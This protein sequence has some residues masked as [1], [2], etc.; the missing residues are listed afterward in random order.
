[1]TNPITILSQNFFKELS[2]ASVNWLLGNVGDKIRVET[3]IQI[4]N[5][6]IASTTSDF[7]VN[8]NDGYIGNGWIIDSAQRFVNFNVGDYVYYYDHVAGAPV[9]GGNFYIIAKQ[10]NGS[11]Q[12]NTLANGTG[13]APTAPA[14]TSD[15]QGV[16][17]NQT[18]IN[19]IKY[20][21]GFIGNNASDSFL[22]PI[23]GSEQVFVIKSKAGSDTSTSQMLPLGTL[24]WQDGNAGSLT[25]DFAGSNISICSI[26]GI[27]AAV[28]AGVYTTTYKIIHYTKIPPYVLFAQITNQTKSPIIPP[29]DFAT[30]GKC[31]KWITQIDAM[32]AYTNPNLFVTQVFDTV[33]GNTGWYNSNFSTQKT[34]YSIDG[35]TYN[36]GA[37]A[38]LN[39]A[40]TATIVNFNI[41]NTVDTPFDADTKLVVGI[42]KVPSDPSEYQNNNTLLD[43]NFL[44]N[45][46]NIQVANTVAGDDSGSTNVLINSTTATLNDSGHVNIDLTIQMNASAVASFQKSSTPRYLI[47]VSVEEDEAPTNTSDLVT[48]QV[49]INTFQSVTTDAGMVVIDKTVFIRHP[50]ANPATE[51]IALVAGVKAFTNQSI[52]GGGPHNFEVIDTT[53][54][55]TIG[56]ANYVTSFANTLSLLAKSINTNTN[57]GTLFDSAPAFD[58]SAG[59]TAV[60]DST[61]SSFI[62][63]APGIGT[64]YNGVVL[65]FEITQPGSPFTFNGTLAGGVNEVSIDVFPQDELVGCSNFYIE[66]SGRTAN[67]IKLTSVNAQIIAQNGTKSFELDQFLMLLSSIPLTGSTQQFD[68]QTPRVFNVPSTSIRKFVE[69][70]RRNDLDTGTRWYFSSNYALMWRWETWTAVLGVDPAFFNTA[71]PNNGFNE[72]WF[73]YAQMAGWNLYYNIIVKATKDGVAQTYT[74][75]LRIIPHDYASNSAYTTKTCLTFDPNGLTALL[76]GSGGAAQLVQSGGSNVTINGQVYSRTGTFYNYMNQKTLIVGVFTKT[77]QPASVCVELKVEIYQQGGIAGERIYSSKWVSDGNTWFTSIDGSGKVVLYAYGNSIIALAYFD[78]TTVAFPITAPSFSFSARIYEIGG[79]LETDD[80]VPL[81]TDD[82]VQIPID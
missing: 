33:L 30:A 29:N 1:M 47:F 13:T 41:V 56:C 51:G 77:T 81:T 27:N 9:D 69:V 45:R 70:K 35:L 24:S 19:A 75:T 18:A 11:I 10:D 62:V 22:S 64:S 58:N 17:S 5:L 73:Q 23:D 48:L 34:N 60:Y 55:K 20:H 57:L 12:L 28:V 53:N 37:L 2:A 43:T 63:Y 42:I 36:T 46:V 74:K 65:K 59:Y 66:S 3:T 49:D 14:N 6:V 61:V 38:S 4:Q 21:Y 79:V 71:L 52:S 40:T 50:E 82:G 72:W 44:F 8:S 25:K 16:I 80:S 39:L 26:A 32:D 67:V 54:N 15:T 7:I 78:P 76:S 68:I 31:W